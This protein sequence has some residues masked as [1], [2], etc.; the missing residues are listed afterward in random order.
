VDKNSKNKWYLF[1]SG[2]WVNKIIGLFELS[3]IVEKKW[4]ELYKV[5]KE[6]G[7]K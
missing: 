3:F 2:E 5:L 1:G 4:E 6:N 7:K